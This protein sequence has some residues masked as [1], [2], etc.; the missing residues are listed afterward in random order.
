MVL[1]AAG[2]GSMINE[3]PRL[4]ATREMYEIYEIRRKIF[5]PGG[6]FLVG[7][8]FRVGYAKTPAGGVCF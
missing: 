2:G 6:L 1:F 8:R 5:S 4:G 3:R 7:V